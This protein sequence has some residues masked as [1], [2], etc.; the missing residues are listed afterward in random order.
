LSIRGTA[1]NRIGGPLSYLY[2]MVLNYERFLKSH[3]K[4]WLKNLMKFVNSGTHAPSWKKGSIQ[5][6]VQ[7]G[8]LVTCIAT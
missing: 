5:V 1:L 4:D 2:H 3:I 7:V 6:L 8:I